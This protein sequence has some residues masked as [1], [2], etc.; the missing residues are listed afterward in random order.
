MK[1]LIED[2]SILTMTTKR[3]NLISRGYIFIDGGII[4]SVGSGNPPDDIETPDL[5]ISGKGRLAIPGMVVLYARLSLYPFR[6]AIAKTQR[7]S[8]I[9]SSMSSTDIHLASILS[10]AGLAMRGITAVLAVDTKV[11]P[12]I[13]ASESVG[14]RVIAAPCLENPS[15]RAQWVQEIG[16]SYRRWHRR[17][18]LS[19]ITGS[20]CSKDAIKGDEISIIPEDMPLIVYGDSCM[21]IRGNRILYVDPHPE[22]DPD[23][24][25]SIY[26]ESHMD[27]WKPGAGYGI[28]SDISWSLT[29]HF[30][31]AR[32]RG[33]NPLDILGSATLWASDKVGLGSGV[34]EPGRPGDIVILDLTQP[35]WWVPGSLVDELIAADIAISSIPRVET[36]IV[37][38]EII[39]DNGEILSVGKEIFS[40]AYNRIHEILGR[41]RNI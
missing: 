11:E 23:P 31:V 30:M 34:I 38:G 27:R 16:S 17:S 15:E 6:G 1:I 28:D 8:E 2:A 33:Y 26:T 36:V 9:L 41:G 19:L 18:P 29:R 7:I 5:V 39:I 25:V 3:E 21:R 14:L 40:R 35:P 13:K 37:G 4:K 10:L 12:V 20:I 22:C 24:N 32:S